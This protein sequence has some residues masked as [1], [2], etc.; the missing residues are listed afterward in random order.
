[1]KTKT[2]PLFSRILLMVFTLIT[3]LSVTLILIAYLSVVHFYQA[4][5][6]L[7]NKDVAAHI[8]KFTS[9]FDQEGLNKQKA[10][11]VFYQ[12]MVISPSVEVYFLDATGRVI[13]FHGSQN[14]VTQPVIS[15]ESIREYLNR[16]GQIYIKGPD[17]RDPSNPKIFS[18]AAVLGKSGI[19]GY[20]YVILGSTEYRSV[21]HLI[22]RSHAGGLIVEIF[23]FIL[24]ATIV[25]TLLYVN[26]LERNFRKLI[27]VLKKFESG[28]LNA[29]FQ[30]NDKNELT[31]VTNAFNKMAG[32]LVDNI[33]KLKRA[34]VERKD[35]TTNISHDLR[36]PLA[37]A[38]GY[39]ETLSLNLESSQA[40]QPANTGYSKLIISNIQ[41]VEH[42]VQQ[43]LD[44]SKMESAAMILQEQPFVFSEIVQ[45]FVHSFSLTAQE[46][47]IAISSVDCENAAWIK[48]D[49]HMM[50]R[51]VQNLLTNALKFTPENGQ[52]R[53]QLTSRQNELIF[54]ISNQGEPMAENL[55]AWLNDNK[56]DASNTRPHSHGLG[57]VI[58]KTILQLHHF[59]MEAGFIEGIGNR[60]AFRM[61][62]TN[63][64][65][66]FN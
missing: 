36:T 22:F 52:I 9:P 17:P 1:M 58:V 16:K 30:E 3:V 34:E 53:I 54:E 46:K 57:L 5:T 60:I 28:D 8:A 43:L 29:R 18:A 13:Y 61:P 56:S 38:R 65:S 10:D 25:L 41:T 45:E 6:Q 42:M 49:I 33:E 51:V 37:I 64:V 21:T 27:L 20:I 50:E 23:L 24:L 35:F 62:V 59:P 12:A 7:L 63:P 19:I 55:L 2:I 44:L 4:S 39:A 11:S 14:E 40:N 26:R 48:A 66:S 15:L 31:P 47:K 32:M